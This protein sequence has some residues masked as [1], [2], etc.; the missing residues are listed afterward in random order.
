M[1]DV[2]LVSDSIAGTCKWEEPSS[3]HKRI[4]IEMVCAKGIKQE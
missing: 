1:P 2:S 4:M 3:D